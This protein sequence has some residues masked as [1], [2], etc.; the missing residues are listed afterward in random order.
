M[1]MLDTVC[2][3]PLAGMAAA[4]ASIY[5]LISRKDIDRSRSHQGKCQKRNCCLDGH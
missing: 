3:E 4:F 2:R 5:P 1:I